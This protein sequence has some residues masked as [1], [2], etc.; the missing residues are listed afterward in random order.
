[1][2]TSSDDASALGA[3]TRINAVNATAT[4]TFRMAATVPQRSHFSRRRA[5]GFAVELLSVSRGVMGNDGCC[6]LPRSKIAHRS[7]APLPPGTPITAPELRE[8]PSMHGHERVDALGGPSVRGYRKSP[9][10]G[11]LGS[12][13][14]NLKL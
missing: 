3:V 2:L 8:Q 12:R 9:L 1:V 7:H 6:R 13:R 4:P 11:T 5:D 14:Q 10:R